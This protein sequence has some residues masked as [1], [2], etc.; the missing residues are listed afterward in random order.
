MAQQGGPTSWNR[1][2]VPHHNLN[3]V[4]ADTHIK[5][6]KCQWTCNTTLQGIY[7]TMGTIQG[8]SHMFNLGHTLEEHCPQ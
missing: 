8:S 1:W 7:L 2:Q 6:A 4:H 5:F 3:W